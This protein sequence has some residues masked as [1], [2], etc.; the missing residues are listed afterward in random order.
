MSFNSWAND[1]AVEPFYRAGRPSDT[2]NIQPRLGF[3][4][5]LNDKTVIRG[6]SGI[7]FAD[8]LTVD[9][10]WAY[11]NG[12][13][14][15][16]QIA[17]DGRP[18]FAANPFNGPAPTFDQAKARLCAFQADLLGVTVRRAAVAETTALGAAFLAGL[19][20][21]FWPSPAAVDHQT[22]GTQASGG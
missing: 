2:N 12:Q 18:D 22:L 7:Y 11:Y 20:E 1:V 9:A 21:D 16:I 14:A 15:T 3:A 17:N 10:F 4:Y 6:G 5:Q 8:A 13:L 19:A